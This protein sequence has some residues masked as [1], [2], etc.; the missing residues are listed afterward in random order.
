LRRLLTENI[1]A[2]LREFFSQ[3]WILNAYNE[4]CPPAKSGTKVIPELRKTRDEWMPSF[5][6]A[7]PE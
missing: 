6:P 3:N 1:D 7:F 5:V 2:D 4:V